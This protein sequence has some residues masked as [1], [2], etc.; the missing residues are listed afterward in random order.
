MWSWNHYCRIQPNFHNCVGIY[1]PTHQLRYSKKT[2]SCSKKPSKTSLCR[3][4]QLLMLGV[5]HWPGLN[6]Q[7]VGHFISQWVICPF[8]HKTWFSSHAIITSVK[9]PISYRNTE[10]LTITC[11]QIGIQPKQALKKL[12]WIYIT[13]HLIKR[14]LQL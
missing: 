2:A 7:N 12:T 5:I 10:K 9:Q 1:F 3:E 11:N 13:V 8:H 14:Q 4:H 6:I